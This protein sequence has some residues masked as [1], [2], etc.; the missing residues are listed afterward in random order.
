MKVILGSASGKKATRLY[1]KYVLIDR[2]VVQSK[3]LHEA[4]VSL[5]LINIKSK[6][7]TTIHLRCTV[8]RIRR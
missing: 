2:K 4:F 6:I 3:V 7:R 5:R 1:Q 8:K